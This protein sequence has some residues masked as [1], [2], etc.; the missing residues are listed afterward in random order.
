MNPQ[1]MTEKELRAEIARISEL[2]REG[3]AT[4]AD[5][6]RFDQCKRNLRL[7]QRSNEFSYEIPRVISP[8][9]QSERIAAQSHS[10][11]KADA[12]EGRAK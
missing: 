12:V 10:R 9:K 11:A 3:D 2:L 1:H 7:I 4:S 8:Q 6:A 5:A